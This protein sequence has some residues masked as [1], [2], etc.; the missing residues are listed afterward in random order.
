MNVIVNYL[1]EVKLELD[2]VI[3]PKRKDVIKLTLVV[4]VIS[5]IMS[6]YLGMLDYTFTKMMES[7]ITN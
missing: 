1:K 5:A 3:W 6:I 7:I 2:K 4:V